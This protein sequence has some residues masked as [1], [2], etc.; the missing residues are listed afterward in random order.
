MLFV[1]LG[2]PGGGKKGKSGGLSTDSE[3][4]EDLAA[5]GFAI[6]DKINQWR[7]VRALWRQV[8]CRLGEG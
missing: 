3:V 6:A 7:Q 2:L 5:K 1:E 8:P 4:L